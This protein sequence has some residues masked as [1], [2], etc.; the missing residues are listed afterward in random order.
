[1][2]TIAIVLGLVTAALSFAGNAA[3]YDIKTPEEMVG[4][5][6]APG[7]IIFRAE[8]ANHKKE[9]LVCQWNTNVFYEFG[10][11]AAQP[12]LSLKKD[13]TEVKV[14]IHDDQYRSA[15]GLAFKNGNVTYHISFINN[16]DN[17]SQESYLLVYNNKTGKEM[18]NITLDPE[19]VVNYIR[20]NFVE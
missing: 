4:D 6:C 1:M 11:I 16:M 20:S 10:K 9:V 18:A 17:G 19:T 5:R 12:E 13:N 2:K 8:T 3:S 15:E 7:D 14:M